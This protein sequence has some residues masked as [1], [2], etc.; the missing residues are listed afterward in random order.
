MEMETTE[1]AE[2]TEVFNCDHDQEL[3]FFTL[4]WHTQ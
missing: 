1:G 3:F 2:S 4:P